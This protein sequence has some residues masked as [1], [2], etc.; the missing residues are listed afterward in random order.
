MSNHPVSDSLSK[1]ALIYSVMKEKNFSDKKLTNSI[2]KHDSPIDPK[3][4]LVTLEEENH[5]L[6][7][8]QNALESNCKIMRHLL[9]GE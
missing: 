3:K 5:Q 8:M 7:Q 9:F 6:K 2:K 4:R 1:K